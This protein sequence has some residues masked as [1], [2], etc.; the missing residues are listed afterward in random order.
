[1]DFIPV[2]G[3]HRLVQNSRQGQFDFTIGDFENHL[4]VLKE[5]GIKS[6]TNEKLTYHKSSGLS[7]DKMV[8]ITFDDGYASDYD[9]ALPV[10]IKNGF[11]GTF[12]I[13]VSHV[14]RPEYLSWDAIRELK[15]EGMSVQSHSFNHVFLSHL[16]Y[17]EII[18]EMKKSKD[19]LE[20]QLGS[21]IEYIAV[22]GGRVSNQVIKAAAEVGYKGVYTSRPGY[23]YNLINKIEVYR[24]FILKNSISRDAYRRIAQKEKIANLKTNCVYGIKRFVRYFIE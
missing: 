15:N 9:A 3:Y 4:A 8:M 5:H 1:M 21:E 22:P 7:T 17:N 2:Y 18:N 24:R 12:F 19:S 14:N 10:L 11:L 20:G 16:K 13:T 6:V 23:S